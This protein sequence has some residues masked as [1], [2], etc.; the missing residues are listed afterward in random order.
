MPETA[1]D[2]RVEAGA[3][4]LFE[5]WAIGEAEALADELGQAGISPEP[6]PWNPEDRHADWYRE[7]ARI[8][9]T[10]ANVVADGKDSSA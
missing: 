1:R 4:A 5:D 6:R 9:L 2:E 7:Q 3:R 10:A 8:V